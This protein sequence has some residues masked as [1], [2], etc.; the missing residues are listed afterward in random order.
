MSRAA[1]LARCR[2]WFHFDEDASLAWFGVGLATLERVEA[3]EV[4]P[5]PELEQ[6][7]DRFL[8]FVGGNAGKVGGQFTLSGPST[9]EPFVHGAAHL[10]AGPV[11][12]SFSEHRP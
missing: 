2:A 5:V 8:Q 1:E 4:V 9:P 6:R 12:P 7:I 11:P 10:A 3:G